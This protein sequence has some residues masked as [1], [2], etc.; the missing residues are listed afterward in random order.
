LII[1]EAEKDFWDYYFEKGDPFTQRFDHRYSHTY[2]AAASVTLNCKKV[3]LPPNPSVHLVPK[4]GSNISEHIGT[5]LDNPTLRCDDSCLSVDFK[6][7][8]LQKCGSAQSVD[9]F[10]QVQEQVLEEGG[11]CKI[12]PKRSWGT[13]DD[14]MHEKEEYKGTWDFSTCII[15]YAETTK[16]QIKSQE[17]EIREKE[18]EIRKKQRR[19]DKTKQ[20]MVMHSQIFEGVPVLATPM[21]RHRTRARL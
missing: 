8:F 14:C 12:R 17:E 20:K 13:F 10:R 19:L 5:F 9:A 3:A 7:A 15:E 4:F 6:P 16:K 18:E 2:T 21:H 11:D 1:D